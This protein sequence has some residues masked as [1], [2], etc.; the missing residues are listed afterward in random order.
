MTGLDYTLVLIAALLFAIMLLPALRRNDFWRAT[1]TPLASI[2]GSGFLVVAPLLAEVAGP[3]GLAAMLGIVIVAYVIGWVIRFNIGQ[4]ENGVPRSALGRVSNLALTLAYVISVAFYIRLLA[5]FALSMTPYDTVFNGNLLASVVLVLI[6]G[7]GYLRGLQGLEALETISVS[8]KLSII[9]AL[10]VGLFTYNAGQGRWLADI[11]ATEMDNWT[12]FRMLA[13]MLLV[14]QGFE[15]SRYLGEAY[16]AKMRI[17]TMRLAQV[18]S[19]MIYAAFIF[20]VLPLMAF[21]PGGKP[22]E[23]AIIDLSGN[24][25]WVLPFMLIL[26]AFMSQL[27]A[28]IADTVG[29]GG[30]VGEETGGRIAARLTYPALVMAAIALI[31]SFDLFQVVSI[32]SRAFAFYYMT[33]ALI[34]FLQARGRPVPQAGFLLVAI[35]MAVIVVVALPVG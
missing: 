13:G 29:A 35:G 28:A 12:R 10:L 33:Q 26:A 7:I 34:A 8:L 17:R 25:A 11:E 6:G 32:A 22:S 19:G 21:L 20:L 3:Y 30:L 27:S 16:S 23:T 14:V 1:V 15:T 2:I 24:V 4:V 31:W 18:L 9:V 5:S